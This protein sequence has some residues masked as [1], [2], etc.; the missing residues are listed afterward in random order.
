MIT[1]ALP[2][3]LLT[4]VLAACA[5]A[6]AQEVDPDQTATLTVRG[7]AQLQ[8][9]ADRLLLRVSVITEADQATDAMA[10]NNSRMHAVVSAIK[11]TG[12]SE[13]E[14]ET[15]R[16]NLQPVYSRRPAR[17]T[18]EWRP[19]ILGYRVTSTLSIKTLQLEKA[20][21][22]I[23]A[24]NDAGAN[25]I[26]SIGFDLADPR[27]HR[28]EAIRTATANAL[29]DARV[30]GEAAG[31]RL[32]RIRTLTLDE[33]AP[34]PIVMQREMM[35]ADGMAMAAPPITPGEVTVRATVTVVYEIEG[36]A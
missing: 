35:V 10:D 24:A 2:A 33:A 6:Y 23:Q 25:A 28:A 27:K 19:E 4:L 11:K 15:G 21:A 13:K 30:L 29:A 16:F 5:T 17:A 7:D 8:K 26:D 31:V 9:P 12:L 1:R 18:P 36:G 14:Y 3:C 32:V 22:I 34:R 20:G